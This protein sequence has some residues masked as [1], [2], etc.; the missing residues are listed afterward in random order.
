ML[1][2]LLVVMPFSFAKPS[3]D[4][5]QY[6]TTIILLIRHAEQP[7][8]G[9]GLSP[10]GQQRAN[11]LVSYFEQY[12]VMGRKIHLD[13]LFA[14]KDSKQ[15]KRPRLTITP[16]SQALRLPIMTPYKNKDYQQLAESLL[17]LITG[18][19]VLICWHHGEMLN[20]ID[21]LGADAAIIF[22]HGK[23]PNKEYGWV[24]QLCYDKAGQLLPG[25]THVVEQEL[26]L[27][28]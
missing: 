5:Q 26:A 18:K 24:V 2:A 27:G 16:L 4:T 9:D 11:A 12:E 28:V 25:L 14:A 20:L 17:P 22:P 1:I 10:E 21:A 23:W 8:K 19:T 7:N 3:V 6:P 15:G 13:A